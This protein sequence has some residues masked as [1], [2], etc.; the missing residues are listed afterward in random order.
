MPMLSLVLPVYNCFEELNAKIPVLIE[1]MGNSDINFEIIIV[2]DGSSEKS[3]VTYSEYLQVRLIT[4]KKN[5]GKGYAVR[6]GVLSANGDCI[7]FM[8]GD[9]PFGIDCVN[10]AYAV[11]NQPKVDIVIGDRTLVDSKFEQSSFMRQMGSKIISFFAG[12]FITPGYFDTQCGIKGFK[13]D[14]ARDIF[15]V[16]KVHGFSFDIEILFIAIRRKY[17]IEK[18]PVIV[19]KQLS[20]NVS[21]FFHGF[22]II[23]NFFRIPINYAMGYYGN[24]KTAGKKL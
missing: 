1:C 14:V 18:I 3:P 19:N 17:V 21:I 2:D 13:K 4:L 20:S 24:K 10:S 5:M 7:I 12:R 23:L 6:Q 16:S 8:D 15:S 22:E 11:L 9:I